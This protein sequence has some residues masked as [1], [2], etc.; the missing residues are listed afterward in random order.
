LFENITSIILNVAF[1]NRISPSQYL[2]ITFLKSSEM[3]PKV[4]FYFGQT[5]I[6]YNIYLQ[7]LFC[8]LKYEKDAFLYFYTNILRKLL[9]FSRMHEKQNIFLFFK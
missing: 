7:Y 9:G 4:F 1:N 3:H 6:D 8:I 2:G 5:I